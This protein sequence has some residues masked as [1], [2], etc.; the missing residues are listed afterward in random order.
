MVITLD[1][2]HAYSIDDIHFYVKLPDG[3]FT[4]HGSAGDLKNRIESR[5]SADHT[6]KYKYDTIIIDNNT[7]RC[8]L[9]RS[10]KPIKRSFEK[11]INWDK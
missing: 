10:F 11:Y 4:K 2:V 6:T 1:T 7:L 5:C 8:N 9:S 3:S